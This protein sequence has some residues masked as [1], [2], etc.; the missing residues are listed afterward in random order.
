MDN[1]PFKTDVIEIKG[2]AKSGKMK[3]VKYDRSFLSRVIQN[4]KAKGFYDT[5]KNYCLSFE[6]VKARASWGAESFLVGNET[7]VK[8]IFVGGVLAVCLA[9]DPAAYNQKDYPHADYSEKRDHKNTPMMLPIRNAAELKL[10][11]RMIGEAFTSH[12]VYTLDF[13]ARTDYPAAL[14]YQSDDALIKKGLI[15]VTKTELSE[16]DAKKAVAA[17][18]RAEAEEEKELEEI[19]GAKKRTKPKKAEPVEEGKEEKPAEEEAPTETAEAVPAPVEDVPAEQPAPEEAPAKKG[20]GFAVLYDRSFTA[21]IIQNERAKNYYSE[22]KNYCLS[23]GMKPR[24]SWRAE[25]FYR[26]RNTYLRM[27]M[28][29]KTL[30]LYFALDPASYDESIFHHKDVSDRKEYQKT[31]MLLRVRSELWVRKAKRLI[32]EMMGAAGFAQSEMPYV[33]Y[34]ALYPFE[35]TDALIEKKLIKKIITDREAIPEDVL[36]ELAE[37]EEEVEFELADD[38]ETLDEEDDAVTEDDAEEVTFEL[39]DEEEEDSEEDVTFELAEEAPTEETKGMES[40]GTEGRDGKYVTLRKYIRGFTAK[41]KQGDQTRKEYYADIKSKLLS[42][43]GV[44]CK[45]SFSGDTFKKGARILLKSRIRGKTLCLFF[46]LDTDQYKQTVY[47][48]QYKGDTKAYAMVPMMV[49][50]KSEQGLKRALRL[51][52]EMERNYILQTGEQASVLDIRKS[53]LYEETPAL[54]EQGLVKTR[55]V[56]VT[57]YEA[58]E[59]LKKKSK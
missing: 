56:T 35:E 16:A 47:R 26:G 32:A 50:V 38:E 2:K 21:R 48:Q 52:E 36:F 9:L 11:R 6:K 19:G 43:Q 14:P 30:Y 12:C 23:F 28:C 51:I 10:A 31:P 13:P 7:V 34:A 37:E 5:I 17:A 18:L 33:D 42:Y 3:V 58:E 55:L 53:Y 27:K 57:R 46:A 49:R 39:A 24:L 29:G 40:Y 22:L 41:M 1:S 15:K 44:K 4:A 45:E 25:S 59:L 54:V 20:F 8:M